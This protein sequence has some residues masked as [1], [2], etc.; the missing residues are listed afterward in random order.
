MKSIEKT[1]KDFFKG[2][3]GIWIFGSFANN[4]YNEKSDIDIAV[5]FKEKKSPVDIFKMQE[6]LFL[7]L[8][9]SVDLVDLANINDVFAYEIVTTGKK[10]KTSD[11]AEDYEYRIWLRYLTLQEDRRII[12]EDFLYG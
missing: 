8:N 1:L 6:E 7:K 12:L 10:I 2:A 3:E 4:T 11:Y 5:L 9:K